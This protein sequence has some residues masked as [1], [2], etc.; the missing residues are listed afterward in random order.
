VN[1]YSRDYAM[2][3]VPVLP[4]P[5]GLCEFTHGIY[6]DEFAEYQSKDIPV[7]QRLG[8]FLPSNGV[9]TGFW[10]ESLDRLAAQRNGVLWNPE[11]LT[12]DYETGFRLH[13]MGYRQL[14]VPLRF[15]SR[16]LAATREYFPRGWRPAV[17]QRSR[18]VGGIALQGWEHFGWSV[19]LRQKY[20]FWRDRKGLLSNLIT[21]AANALFI[22]GLASFF[23]NW[24]GLGRY[25]ALLPRWVLPAGVLNLAISAIQLSVRV[26]CTSRIYGSAFAWAAPLR[27]F[28]GNMM[29]CTATV[30]ALAQFLRA[31]RNHSH[32][33]WLKTDHLYPAQQLEVA[34][35]RLGEV[36]V[37]MRC[38]PMSV[39]EEALVSG[40][41]G[42]R[43]GEYLVNTRK[44]SEQNLYQALSCQAG[45]PLGAPRQGEVNL[46]VTRLFPMQLA[47]RWK[48][49][50]YRV[51]IGQLHVLTPNLP[52]E[53]MTRELAEIC[54]LELRFH[55]TP[56]GQFEELTRKYWETEQ[57]PA[58]RSGG[59]AKPIDILPQPVSAS[60]PRLPAHISMRS[61]APAQT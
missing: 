51:E 53:E 45:I 54:Q 35:P 10:R 25:A 24:G 21:P 26:C 12:E 6:C 30:K 49:L 14:F 33:A 39:V 28:W 20:W 23:T 42:L 37:R 56:P 13:S 58:P 9:G 34:R 38:V 60:R 3:Q 29:N 36:L 41:N 1:W 18:W 57:R 17:R 16:D 32:V 11:C 4:L 22:C 19:P 31:R 52:T 8:G 46:R 55:L 59:T 7:R 2:V 50:P 5:T 48:V 15:G 44:L 47:R 61:L 40:R 43:L 27:I